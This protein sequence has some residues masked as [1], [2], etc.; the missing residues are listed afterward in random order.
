MSPRGTDKEIAQKAR[1]YCSLHRRAVSL[2]T[3]NLNSYFK[4]EAKRERV[5][6]ELLEL[7]K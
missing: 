6:N 3:R 2:I 7:C 4:L 5:L 1:E